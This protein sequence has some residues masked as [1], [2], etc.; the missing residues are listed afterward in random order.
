MAVI[1]TLLSVQPPGPRGKFLIDTCRRWQ[2]DVPTSDD[3]KTAFV[4]SPDA[5]DKLSAKIAPIMARRKEFG[6]VGRGGKRGTDEASQ[7]ST[8][9]TGEAAFTAISGDAYHGLISASDGGILG[10]G[11]ESSGEMGIVQMK[12][13]TAKAV[14]PPFRRNIHTHNINAGG[15][16]HAAVANPLSPVTPNPSQH[17]PANNIN[18]D[19]KPPTEINTSKIHRFIPIGQGV[20]GNSM[21]GVQEALPQSVVNLPYTPAR[22]PVDEYYEDT[23][24]I[25]TST[26]R[27]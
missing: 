27:F 16:N 1:K 13:V 17:F 26:R 8:R 6:F 5:L 10:G 3:D 2:L 4:T 24:D 9:T 14:P 20:S 12:P 11:V 22:T 19:D 25:P 23:G 15:P 21:Y 18:N 7:C